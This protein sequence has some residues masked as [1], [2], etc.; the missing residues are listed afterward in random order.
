MKPSLVLVAFLSPSDP[1]LRAWT[2]FRLGLRDIR[3]TEADLVGP[4][5]A[6]AAAAAAAAASGSAAASGFWLILSTN[7]REIGRGTLLY[8]SSSAARMHLRLLQSLTDRMTV[9][10]VT[11]PSAGTHGWLV[12][13][14][15]REVMSCAR[16]YA[17]GPAA[18][19]AANATV[20]A[21]QLAVFS[22]SPR[23]GSAAIRANEW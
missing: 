16:W 10:I 11:G 1:M 22:P 6:V 3:P 2:A 7:N 20:A 18:R 15:D 21:L 13:A 4:D 12:S 5:R 19:R 14:G 9:S 8:S 23:A 17:S